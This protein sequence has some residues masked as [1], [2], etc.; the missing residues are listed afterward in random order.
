M[1]NARTTTLSTIV[2]HKPSIFIPYLA[3]WIF[4]NFSTYNHDHQIILYIILKVMNRR[5]TIRDI[6]KMCD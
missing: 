2:H 1:L 5:Y 4:P 6:S 3:Q